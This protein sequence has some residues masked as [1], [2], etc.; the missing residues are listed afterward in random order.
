MSW[1]FSA[2]VV[3]DRRPLCSTAHFV[4]AKCCFVVD[5]RTVA[6]DN[7]LDLSFVITE[8]IW[9]TDIHWHGFNPETEHEGPCPQSWVWTERNKKYPLTTDRGMKITKFLVHFEALVLHSNAVS[10]LQQMSAGCCCWFHTISSL[11]PSES[12][13]LGPLWWLLMAIVLSQLWLITGLKNTEIHIC[14]MCQT[15]VPSVNPQQGLRDEWFTGSTAV[16]T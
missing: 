13:E 15:A 14:F 8:L 6:V 4:S 12:L 7:V 16:L 5:L 1:N 9:V 10:I 2:A 11:C 3:K